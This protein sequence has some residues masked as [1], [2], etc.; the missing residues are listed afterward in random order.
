V[1]IEQSVAGPTVRVRAPR[2]WGALIFLPI[3]LA[4]WTF[5]GV[6]AIGSFLR[7]P[8]LFLGVWLLGWAAG[9]AFAVLAW[10][11]AAFG[12][13]VLTIGERVISVAKRIGPFQ[14]ARSHPLH[15]ASD[16]R[17]AGWFGS[18]TS[19]SDSM[20]PWGLTGGTL[21]FD[22]SGKPVRFGIGLNEHEARQLAAELAPYMRGAA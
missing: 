9:E 2:N 22:H 3:W 5:G 20:R 17:A 19:F 11:W 6:L 21:A 14:K 7:E 4:G 8:Q 16:I 13:E 1:R 15:E 12:E 18:P 10:S